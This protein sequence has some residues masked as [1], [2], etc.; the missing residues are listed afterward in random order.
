MGLC[1]VSII[2]SCCSV[3]V[4]VSN[5]H[6]MPPFCLFCYYLSIYIYRPGILADV[7]SRIAKKGMSLEDVSTTLRYNTTTHQR[8][9]VID[10]LASSSNTHDKDN[11]DTYVTELRTSFEQDLHLSSMDI[12]VHTK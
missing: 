10:V 9:F 1:V 4:S 5:T 2:R 8:E 11:L 6:R 7:T 12:R 3:F